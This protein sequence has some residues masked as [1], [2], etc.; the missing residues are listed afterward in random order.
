MSCSSRA[1]RA[2]LLRHGYA[3]RCI[4]FA[5]GLGR[6]Y[7]CRFSLLGALAKGIPSEPADPEQQR[8]EDQLASRMCG[9]VVDD[10]C[11]SADHDSQP[12]PSSRGV[13]QVSE[14]E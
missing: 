3:R 6:T 8:D 7:V 14:E 2:P 12:Y 11:G 13:A 10:D 1:I 5:F 4:P 9:F